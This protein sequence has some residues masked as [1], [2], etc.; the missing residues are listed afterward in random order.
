MRSV[1][2]DNNPKQMEKVGLK[3]GVRPQF[4]RGMEISISSTIEYYWAM[5]TM[6]YA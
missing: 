6:A 1:M 2:V 4:E 5:R 3:G